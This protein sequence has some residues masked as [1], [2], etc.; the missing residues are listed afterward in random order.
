MLLWKRMWENE[1][2]D[3]S[4]SAGMTVEHRESSIVPSAQLTAIKL[5]LV[6]GISTAMTDC[7]ERMTLQ[8]CSMRLGV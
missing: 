5:S 7:S 2:Q 8:H 1:H 4:G 6:H 3:A